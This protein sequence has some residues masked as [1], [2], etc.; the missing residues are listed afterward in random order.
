VD[1]AQS[2]PSSVANRSLLLV[3]LLLA[4]SHTHLRPT[5]SSDK[6]SIDTYGDEEQ[7]VRHAGRSWDDS[8]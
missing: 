2:L 4:L 1:Q 5:M 7:L 8:P 6:D 3:L